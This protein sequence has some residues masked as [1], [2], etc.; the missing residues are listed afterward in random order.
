VPSLPLTFHTPQLSALVANFYASDAEIQRA[1]RAAVKRAGD[2]MFEIAE[3]LCAV[4][5]GFMVEH[6][7]ER[8]TEGGYAVSIGWDAADFEDAGLAFYPPFVEFGTSKMAA[9]PAI[10]PAFE[11]VAPEFE[12]ELA[13]VVTAAI[14]R[15]F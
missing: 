8:I 5:T 3:A 9:Q 6:M 15:T 11:I 7:R 13:A 1:A 10:G 14:E 2:A 4:D 12:A